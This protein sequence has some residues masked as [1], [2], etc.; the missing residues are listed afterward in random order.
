[1]VR[2]TAR[3][4]R[5]RRGEERPP[6]LG[7]AQRVAA[8]RAR[9]RGARGPGP[10]AGAGGQVEHIRRIPSCRGAPDIFL[11]RGV[12]FLRPIRSFSAP[13]S[14]STRAPEKRTLCYAPRQPSD[15]A[16]EGCS[17]DA[18]YLWH[19]FRVQSSHRSARIRPLRQRGPRRRGG[20]RGSSRRESA[21]PGSSPRARRSDSAIASRGPRVHS[22][23]LPGHE[24]RRGSAG[25]RQLRNAPLSS[26]CRGYRTRRSQRCALV[27]GTHGSRR[28]AIR[29]GGMLH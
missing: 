4:D 23:H 16:E 19:A 29:R 18:L 11:S 25:R 9:D 26:A 1:M 7:P 22:S 28:G 10:A 3:R 14:I 12:S 24:R 20:R 13:G 2:P 27:D 17:I 6:D 21:R 5:P 8:G 15:D